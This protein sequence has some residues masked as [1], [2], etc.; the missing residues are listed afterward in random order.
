MF[1]KRWIVLLILGLMLGVPAE[2]QELGYRRVT[3]KDR[4]KEFYRTGGRSHLGK[5]VH[6]LIPASVFRKEPKKV[7]RPGGTILHVFSNRSVP[8]IVSMK[9]IYFKRLKRKMAKK[10]KRIQTV[11]VFGKVF[12][13]TWDMKGRCHLQVHKMKSYNGKL[14]KTGG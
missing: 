14:M 1:T 2:T 5:K 4:L 9:N 11:S 8:L 7:R 6:I 3:M 10:G 13:P 12:Q